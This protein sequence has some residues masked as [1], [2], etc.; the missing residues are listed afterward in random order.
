M[1]MSVQKVDIDVS[2]YW[3]ESVFF[4]ILCNRFLGTYFFF[5]VLVFFQFQVSNFDFDFPN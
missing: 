2:I 3:F 4:S 5:Y 1:R